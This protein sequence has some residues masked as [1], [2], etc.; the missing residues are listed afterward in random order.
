M[1]PMSFF[2]CCLP[3]MIITAP[4]RAKMREKF[5]GFKSFSAT[6]EVSKPTSDS[7]HAVR[8]VPMLEPMMTPT[9]WEMSIM[10][11]FTRPTSI[12]VMAEEDWMA[13]VMPAPKARDFHKLEVMRRSA[14]SSLPPAIR[15]RPEDMTF[16]P[17]R[18]KAKPPPSIIKEKRSIWQYAPFFQK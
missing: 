8:V 10:P 7:S 14:P 15:S 16:I 11:E 6:L 18:K 13:M 1:E 5:S 2:R 9:V 4:T 17:Y 12:T 3:I